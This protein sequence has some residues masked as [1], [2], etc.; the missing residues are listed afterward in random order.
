MGYASS[1]LMTATA[2]LTPNVKVRTRQKYASCAICVYLEISTIPA[3]G[4]AP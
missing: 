2:A 1:A 4:H 3:V